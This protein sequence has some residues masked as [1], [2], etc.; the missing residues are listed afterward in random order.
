MPIRS[1]IFFNGVNGMLIPAWI[2]F[3]AGKLVLLVLTVNLSFTNRWN[4]FYGSLVPL[5]FVGLWPTLWDF[6]SDRLVAVPMMDGH[7]DGQ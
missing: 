1:L 4:F 3:Y 7:T 5:E 2:S 6:S